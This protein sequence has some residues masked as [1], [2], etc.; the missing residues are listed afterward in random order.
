[1]RISI[2]MLAAVTAAGITF[3]TAGPAVAQSTGFTGPWLAAIT[4]ADPGQG[5]AL[6]AEPASA[7]APSIASAAARS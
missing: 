2:A 4:D 5:L 7:S 3:M 6:G 1:M